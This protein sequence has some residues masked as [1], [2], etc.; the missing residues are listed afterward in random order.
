MV[1]DVD[2]SKKPV[3]SAVLVMIN[4]M[5]VR[6]CN[7]FHTI[8]ANNDK[9]TFFRGVPFFDALVRGEPLHP[10]ARNFVRIK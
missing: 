9:M 1:I 4:S 2:K 10:V 6:I 3:T 7:R 5:S 8:R